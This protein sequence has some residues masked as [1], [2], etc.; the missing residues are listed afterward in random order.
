MNT[1]VLVTYA[2]KYGAT[3]EIAE[4]IGQVIAEAGLETDVLPLK[5]VTSL[6]PYDVVVLGSA[7]YIGRWR[8][9]ARKFIRRY[10]Q[11]LAARDVRIFLSG[12]TGEGGAEAVREAWHLSKKLGRSLE[13]I[14]PRDVIVFRGAIDVDKLSDLEKWMIKRVEA[15]VGD[16]RDWDAITAWA[17]GI[18]DGVKNVTLQAT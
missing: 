1:K 17:Q 10:E 8:K 16:F 6:N 15:P 14:A 2:S 7:L 3:R 12:P 9:E 5:K 13:H 18:A 4:K 11:K